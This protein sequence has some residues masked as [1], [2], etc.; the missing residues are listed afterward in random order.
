MSDL[1]EGMTP[2][3]EAPR[4]VGS[5]HL[6]YFDV[7]PRGLN[8]KGNRREEPNTPAYQKDRTH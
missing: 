5:G 1:K 6:C 7:S 3:L 4:R 2:T 8:V